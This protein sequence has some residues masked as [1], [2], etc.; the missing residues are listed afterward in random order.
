MRKWELE[1]ERT[2]SGTTLS[3]NN[4]KGRIV[5]ECRSR[6][7]G[8]FQLMGFNFRYESLEL[9]DRNQGDGNSYKVDHMATMK[10]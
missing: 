7:P 6:L 9:I 3:K 5:A 10:C 1:I 8:I 4:N 2:S